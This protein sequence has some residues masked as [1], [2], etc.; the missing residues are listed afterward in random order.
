[1]VFRKIRYTPLLRAGFRILSMNEK[2]IINA[3]VKYAPEDVS[4]KWLGAIG[5]FIVITA[6]ILPF[7]LWGLYGHLKASYGHGAAIPEAKNLEK[8]DQP[9]APDLKPRPVENYREFRRAESEKLNDYGWVDK[10]KGIVHI[11]I[12][13]AMQMIANKGLPDVKPTNDN[14]NSVPNNLPA[15]NVNTANQPMKKEK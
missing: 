6:I 10:E 5:V 12:E 14:A 1:M 9:P 15:A 2:E 4:G 3:D 13:Q 8:F 7:L 11:P